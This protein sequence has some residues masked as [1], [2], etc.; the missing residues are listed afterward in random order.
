[1]QRRNTLY[2]VPTLGSCEIRWFSQNGL[3]CEQL[4]S[5]RRRYIHFKMKLCQV[6]ED[7]YACSQLQS[8]VRKKAFT[9]VLQYYIATTTID[10]NVL[11]YQTDL[12]AVFYQALII[13]H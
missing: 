9:F 7:F 4:Y 12:E 8:S 13:G 3:S 2:A 1:M 10:R 11:I 5:V 6:Q